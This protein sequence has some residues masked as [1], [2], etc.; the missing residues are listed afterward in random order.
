MG[1]GEI[2]V[3]AIVGFFAGYGLSRLAF[4]VLD[5]LR[6]RKAR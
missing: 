1:W 5:W 2:S 6:S 3:F 4:D